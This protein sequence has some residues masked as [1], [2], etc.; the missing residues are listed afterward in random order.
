MTYPKD[1][2]KDTQKYLDGLIHLNTLSQKYTNEQISE[3]MWILSN[4]EVT[5]IEED[6]EMKKLSKQIDF[7]KSL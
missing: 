4:E 3:A 2:L 5:E 7:I 6:F 1:L